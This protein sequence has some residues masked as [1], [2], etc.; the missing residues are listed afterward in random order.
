M[1]DDLKTDLMRDMLAEW[2]NGLALSWE[3]NAR[4][5]KARP[6]RTLPACGQVSHDL[7]PNRHLRGAAASSGMWCGRL[8]GWETKP[9]GGTR[10]LGGLW[11]QPMKWGRTGGGRP[12]WGDPLI[13]STILAVFET[14]APKRRPERP[15]GAWPPT[16]PTVPV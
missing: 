3:A 6:S 1:L 16:A 10:G 13:R 11:R 4:P 12:I 15:P 8:V 5:T 2:Q 9:A 7:G 14:E